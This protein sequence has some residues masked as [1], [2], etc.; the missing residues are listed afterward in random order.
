MIF[1]VNALVFDGSPS[2]KSGNAGVCGGYL[3]Y[4]FGVG[5]ESRN[6]PM[7]YPDGYGYQMK[8]TEQWGANIHLL[9][10][11]DIEGGAQG[12][13]D[14][15]ECKYWEGRSPGCHEDESGLFA[16][17]G[18]GTFCKTTAKGKFGAAKTYYLRYAVTY[19]T[20]V[21]SVKPL[22]LYV[23]D[24]SNCKIEYN[25][26]ADAKSKEHMDLC[27]TVPENGAGEIVFAQGHQH[28]GG[29][30]IS[31][32][33]G[34]THRSAVSIC[35][36]YPTYGTAKG[37]PGNEKGYLTAMSHCNRP[38]VTIKAGEQ[39]CVNSTYIVDPKDQR[40]APIPGGSH[41]GVMSLFYAAVHL[42]KVTENHHQ[43]D[44]VV[45]PV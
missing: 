44:W 17:C 10:T 9:R 45:T 24:S 19:T 35:D 15:I 2:S 16:C 31:L 33:H 14:C 39:I 26:A 7:E 28:I 3:S 30:K 37:V 8:G 40:S 36:S 38:N 4:I 21:N 41:G 25:I 6:S 29:E 34:P 23:F 11:V 5:A 1:L 43:L 18:D 42:D 13:K 27:W 22:A 12:T 20:N 32:L